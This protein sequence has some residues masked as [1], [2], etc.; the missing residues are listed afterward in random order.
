MI[1]LVLGNK[2]YQLLEEALRSRCRIQPVVGC[3]EAGLHVGV[4]LEKTDIP[5]A[6][7]CGIERRLLHRHGN[8]HP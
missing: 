1:R 5:G 8:G 6:A 7:G 4:L 3:I 2:F